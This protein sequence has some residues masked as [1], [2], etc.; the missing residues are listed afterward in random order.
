MRNNHPE[1]P[2]QLSSPNSKSNRALSHAATE[3][4][5]LGE[6]YLDCGPLDADEAEPWRPTIDTLKK[7]YQVP[8]AADLHPSLAF[9]DNP[10][11]SPSFGTVFPGVLEQLRKVR[12]FLI[13]KGFN[14][15]ADPVNP[16]GDG[17]SWALV[18]ERTHSSTGADPLELVRQCQA[19]IVSSAAEPVRDGQTILVPLWQLNVN[20]T[21]MEE[22]PQ[23]LSSSEPSGVERGKKASQY[24]AELR[25]LGHSCKG[26]RRCD[27]TQLR[28][29][30]PAF[31]IW[32]AI[33]DS[34]VSAI[35][36]EEFFSDPAARM[37]QDR[38]DLIGGILGVS[39]ARA[40][41]YL[42]SFNMASGKTRRRRNRS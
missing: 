2:K 22:Q 21:A 9:A 12:G 11:P 15:D 34:R 17:K 30:F 6:V 38:F 20:G 25:R 32:K 7:I 33:D 5:N 28:Q 27:E 16:L 24:D 18:V 4:D 26:K 3:G 42:K 36:R 37:L 13:V 8:S 41:D 19:Q 10:W 23:P 1:V 29:E 31:T 40:Y 14:V 35:K 39:G